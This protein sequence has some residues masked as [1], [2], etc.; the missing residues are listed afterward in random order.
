MIVSLPM[1]LP[2][3]DAVQS[4]W[5]EVSGLLAPR[6]KHPVPDALFWPQDLYAHWLE[7]ALLLSQTCGY[8]LST[9]LRN[10]VQV[11]GTFT[12]NAPG[13]QGIYCKSQLIRR[14]NDG[15]TSL[16]QFAGSTLTFNGSDSQSGFNALRALVATTQPQRPFFG[17]AVQSG[18]H[19]ASIEKVRGGEADMAAVD[20]VTLAIWRD[21]HPQL[22]KDIAVFG[23][24]AAY[25]GLPLITSL[26]TP[27]DTLAQLRECLAAIATEARFAAVRAPFHISGFE[28]TGLNDYNVCLQ[29]EKAGAPL[30]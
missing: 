23:E 8:P 24:T 30:F 11:V 13:C 10:K 25:P 18:G 17:G 3:G 20:C 21:M 9:T 15:R 7:P 27:A 2:G 6:L 4:F 29:M 19:S 28:I 1:Y 16:S 14:S 26:S 12:Y 22:A 5:A